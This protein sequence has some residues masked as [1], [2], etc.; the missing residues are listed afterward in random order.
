MG[1]KSKRE[2]ALQTYTKHDISEAKRYLGYYVESYTQGESTRS[3]CFTKEAVTSD[4]IM[5]VIVKYFTY[6]GV[7]FTYEYG[8]NWMDVYY[9]LEINFK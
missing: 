8:K 7:D 2:L 5:K 6:L 1:I 9:K 3:Y 4:K